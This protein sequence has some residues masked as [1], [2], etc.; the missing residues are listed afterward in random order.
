[1]DLELRQQITELETMTVGQMKDKYLQLF[2]EDT[3]SRNR[4][5]LYRRLA[6]RLQAMKE[7]GLSERAKKRA[8]ELAHDVDIRIRPPKDMFMEEPENA[9]ASK[10]KITLKWDERLPIPGTTLTREYKGFKYRVAV[11]T[12]G[13]EYDGKIYRSLSAV[14]YAITG[15]HWNG[16]HFFKESL[17]QVG[18]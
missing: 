5:W 12:N 14:A 18:G 6:W 11:L 3:R 8:L 7:G 4:Q 15:C 13:F 10:G 2:Q 1:M 16:F 9:P 17:N